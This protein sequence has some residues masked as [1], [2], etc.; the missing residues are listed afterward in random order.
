M[1]SLTEDEHIRIKETFDEYDVDGNGSVQ[2]SEME[3]MIKMRI[4]DR[5]AAVE[6]KFQEFSA[7]CPSEEELA[8]AEEQ[9][10][11]YLQH[12]TESQNKML[13]MF[14]MADLDG[15]GELSYTEFILAEAWFMRCA[16][17]PD[18]AHLF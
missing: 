15:N 12:L 9:K 11:S 17:N 3:Q 6:E 1:K 18:H 8:R 4:A 13:K 5:K 7:D 2:L 14:S 16:I 10:R